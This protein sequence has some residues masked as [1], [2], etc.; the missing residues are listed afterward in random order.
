[1]KNIVSL[2]TI[3]AVLFAACIVYLIYGLYQRS[4]QEEERQLR[5]AR[6]IETMILEKHE[7]Q[8]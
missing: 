8:P 4:S 2:K 6:R 3:L 5:D 1:M 7:R